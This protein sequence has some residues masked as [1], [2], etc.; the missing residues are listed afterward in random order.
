LLIHTQGRREGGAVGARA[1]PP[2]GPV[3][4]GIFRHSRTSPVGLGLEQ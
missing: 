3:V 4:R 2:G 1:L